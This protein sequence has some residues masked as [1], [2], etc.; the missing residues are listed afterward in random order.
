MAVKPDKPGFVSRQWRSA[1][2]RGVDTVSEYADVAAQK[3][4]AAADPRARLLRKR[5]W[6]LRLGLFFGFATVFWVAVTG[7]LATW[8]TPVWGLIITGVI[9]AG[10]AVPATLLLLRYRWLRR[11]PLPPQRQVSGRRLPPHGSVARPSVSA[12]G[13]SERGFHSLLGVMTRG[14]M[15]P[16]E[17]I[18]E[19]SEAADRTAATMAATAAEVVSM[20]RAAIETPHSQSYLAPTIN[21]FTAQ[22]NAGVRQY[23]EMVTAAAQLVSA[24]NTG[25][26]SSSPMSQQRYRNELAGAT[27]RLMGWAQAFDELGQL[28]R[29]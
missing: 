28:R 29:A 10:A 13:A 14:N 26:M 21:A 12:L 22:L 9:A 15:L 16:P 6:A 7:L 5:R 8:S 24:A 20:E 25:A 17:E 18:R 11:E 4:S 23:N 19:L 27:D 2:Q 1:M 3:L